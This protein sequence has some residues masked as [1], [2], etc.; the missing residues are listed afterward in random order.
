MIWLGS[1]R[2]SHATGAEVAVH[3]SGAWV[4][5]S[6]RGANTIVTF[7]SN[8]ATGALSLVEHTPARGGVTSAAR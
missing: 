4:Y 6:V 3:P 2:V 8:A 1:G 7:A 5:G